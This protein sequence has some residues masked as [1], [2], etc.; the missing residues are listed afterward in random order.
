MD[1]EL[2][3][4]A[5]CLNLKCYRVCNTRQI[6]HQGKLWSVKKWNFGPITRSK[7]HIKTL[8][9]I[10][11]MTYS[12]NQAVHHRVKPR[13]GHFQTTVNKRQM[14]YVDPLVGETISHEKTTLTTQTRRKMRLPTTLKKHG[15]ID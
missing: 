13:R 2:I 11:Y 14:R 15:L 9:F 5:L 7:N 10:V 1:F 3:T 6:Q 8:R 4:K 12:E